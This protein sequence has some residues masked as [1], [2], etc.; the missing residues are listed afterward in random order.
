MSLKRTI[1]NLEQIT[2]GFD[3][4]IANLEILLKEIRPRTNVRNSRI[5]HIRRDLDKL[6]ELDIP[7]MKK[8]FELAIKLNQLNIIFDNKI[9]FNKEDVIKLVEGKYDLVNDDKVQSHDFVFEF[10]TGARFALA[11]GSS[12]KVSLSGQGDITVGEE[13]AVE[14]KNIR[15]L[16]NLVKNVDKAKKQIEARVDKGEVKSGFISLDISNIY[17]AE[18]VQEFFQKIFE[19][20]YR[21]HAKLKEFQRFDQDAID[22]VLEDRNFQK[23]IQSYMMHEAESA[24]YS[25]LPLRYNMGSATLGITFQVSTCFV[26]KGGDEYIPIPI[27]GMTYILNSGLSENSYQTVKAYIHSLAVGF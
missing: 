1:H 16:N 6:F 4:L 15:S 20:F 12:K 3:K 9:E 14:C 25:A 2:S 21:N 19:D 7:E 18:K 27:R 26:I 8:L 13:I 10:L 22:S 17:S 23:I 5:G 24:L 11:I